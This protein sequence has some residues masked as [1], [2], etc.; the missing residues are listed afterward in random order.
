[1]KNRYER[2]SEKS[3]GKFEMVEGRELEVR[4]PMDGSGNLHR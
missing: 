3:K 2:A 4:L 1:V